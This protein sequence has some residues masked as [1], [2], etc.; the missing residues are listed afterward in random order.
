VPVPIIF[1][2]IFGQD[3]SDSK[4]NGLH[5]DIFHVCFIH[6]ALFNCYQPF[7]SI[8]SSQCLMQVYLVESASVVHAMM[9]E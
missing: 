9:G 8:I 6:I 3:L 7:V 5:A 4:S 1:L 2:G